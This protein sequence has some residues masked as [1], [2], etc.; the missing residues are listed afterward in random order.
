[1]YIIFHPTNIYVFIIK[2]F[3]H[4]RRG[5]ENPASAHILSEW[6]KI[7]AVDQPDKSG[8]GPSVSH[9]RCECPALGRRA[10]EGRTALI[11]TSQDYLIP[12]VNLAIWFFFL[13]SPKVKPNYS[14]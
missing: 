5:P 3:Y 11:P 10:E 14:S 9:V 13:R 1:M 7:P 2:S 8:I 4:N 12:F 6:V